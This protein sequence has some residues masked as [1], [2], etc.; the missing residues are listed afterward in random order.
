MG[1]QS[2]T[3]LSD[4]AHKQRAEAGGIL[5]RG[6]PIC[7]LPPSPNKAGSAQVELPQLTPAPGPRVQASLASELWDPVGRREHPF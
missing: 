2:Q 7:V 4:W 3:Q 1:S 6:F 5:L